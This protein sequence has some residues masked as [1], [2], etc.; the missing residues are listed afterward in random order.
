MGAF[1]VLMALKRSLR[2]HA[3]LL[4]EVL[5]VSIGFALYTNSMESLMA[6]ESHTNIMTNTINNCK[7]ERQA[8]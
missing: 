8:P 2:E 4:K 6:L 5:S 3:H 1:V 7:I